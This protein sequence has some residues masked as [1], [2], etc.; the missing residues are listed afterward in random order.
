MATIPEPSR[1]SVLLRQA[2]PAAL[3]GVAAGLMLIGFEGAVHK[4]EHLV[5][6]TLPSSLGVATESWWWPV[7]VLGIAGLAVGA[8]LHL[9]PGHGGHDPATTGL[10]AAPISVRDALGMVLAS[11]ITL[12]CGVS[13]GPEAALLGLFSAMLAVVAARRDLPVQ[14]VVTLG[15]AG[16]LGALFGAPVGAAF[17]F[18][19]M[20][21]LAGEELYEKLVPLFVA[22]ST[23]ALSVVLVAGR[24]QLSIPLSAPR[25]FIVTDVLSAAVIGILGAL[26]GLVVGEV[27][28]RIYPLAHRIPLVAR[29]T[30]GGLALGGIAAVSGELVLFSGQAELPELLTLDATGGKLPLLLIGKI[31][32]V[33]IAL[34]VGF[35]G[36]KIFPGVFIGVALGVLI[37]GLLPGVPLTLAVGAATVGVV[38]AFVRFWLL[39]L[40]M[41]ALIVGVDVIPLLGVALVA[42]YL[43]V[44]LAPEVLV[45]TD[46]EPAG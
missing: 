25:D 9:V 4:L 17:A 7:G 15:M 5:W 34:A 29:V 20:T 37:N 8:V 35:R 3:I 13:L 41:V 30:L 27:L 43:V 26:A 1:T 44:R 32:S 24:P 22:S 46:A 14:G 38:L 39:S 45:H 6:S 40:L 16:L 10:M 2:V 36:G 28:R 33:T 42:A 23:G 31:L 21:P 12:A 19:E 11:L 18:V